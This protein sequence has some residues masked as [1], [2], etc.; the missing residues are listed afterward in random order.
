MVFL[1]VIHAGLIIWAST[2]AISFLYRVDLSSE[3]V[4]VNE[5]LEVFGEQNVDWTDVSADT[6][7]R[8]AHIR[9]GSRTNLDGTTRADEILEFG[10][11]RGEQF[12]PK[13]LLRSEGDGTLE[14]VT[15]GNKLALSPNGGN[16]GVGTSSPNAKLDVAGETIIRG[17]A[18]VGGNNQT[19]TLKID[20]QGTSTVGIQL[21][22][23]P[24]SE[25]S[26][27]AARRKLLDSNGSDITASPY[28]FNKKS[29]GVYSM[30]GGEQVVM[31]RGNNTVLSF[32]E[33]ENTEM[34]AEQNVVIQAHHGDVNLVSNN[35]KIRFHGAIELGGSDLTGGISNTLGQKN[36][37]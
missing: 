7:T 21:G 3:S 2:L 10:T 14:V 1:I 22:P 6:M 37:K 35:G 32:T 30:V 26:V 15:N 23:D 11:Y 34:Y 24:T 13:S 18:S 4:K 5:A 8:Q 9:I 29:F 33:G 12:V 19:S 20:S 25:A 16:V 36:G 17:N 27:S 28:G 31:K